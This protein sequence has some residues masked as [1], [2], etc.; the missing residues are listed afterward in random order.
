MHFINKCLY[1]S[2]Y[3]ILYTQTVLHTNF[4]TQL[5]LPTGGFTHRNFS[6][7]SMVCRRNLYKQVF[8]HS[9]NFTHRNLHTQKP[10]QTN[11][12]TYRAVKHKCFFTQTLLH[13][14]VSGRRI[15]TQMFLPAGIFTHDVSHSD[16]FTKKL[17]TRMLLPLLHGGV[18]NRSYLHTGSHRFYAKKFCA[19][20]VLHRRLYT[21]CFFNRCF[22]TQMPLHTK[23]VF[24]HRH[25]LHTEAYCIQQEFFAHRGFETQALLHTEALTHRQFLHT[26]A[27]THRCFTHK[28]LH[29]QTPLHAE[30]LTQMFLLRSLY[31]Q[32]GSYTQKPLHTPAPLHTKAFTHRCFCAGKAFAH[33]NPFPPVLDDRRAFRAGNVYRGQTE[34]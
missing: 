27:F 8:L 30:L 5:F 21:H 15:Y 1:E 26:E 10:L 6:Y 2:L 9:G 18:L 34:S 12:Y 16:G 31:K 19:Q 20:M 17:Y 25:F 33:K 11:I 22:Y 3:T 32:M 13:T 14:E 4:D 28:Y 24:T 23:G 7:K 29:P